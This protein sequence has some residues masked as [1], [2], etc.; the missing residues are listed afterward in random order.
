MMRTPSYAELSPMHGTVLQMRLLPEYL[1][2]KLL[3]VSLNPARKWATHFARLLKHYV[4][5]KSRCMCGAAA[6]HAG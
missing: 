5:T 3:V 4:R 6:I 2:R 1:N